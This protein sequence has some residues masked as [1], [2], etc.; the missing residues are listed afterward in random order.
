M[1]LNGHTYYS[2]KYGVLS[3]EA[4]AE[5]ASRRGITTLALTDINNTSCAVEWIS[6]CRKRDIKPV[7]GIEY[8]TTVETISIGRYLYTGIAKNAEGW[9]ELCELLTA[10]SLDGVPLPQRPPEMEHVYIIYRPDVFV[11]SDLRPNEF[12]GIKPAEA[13]GLYT[14]DWRNRLDRLVVWQPVTFDDDTG[15]KVHKLMRCVDL[16]IM[17]GQLEPD[18]CA[19]ADE[20]WV[21][22][23]Y[24]DNAFRGYPQI[25][26]NTESLLYQCEIEL[27]RTDKNNR[28]TFTGSERDDHQLLLKLAREGCRRRYGQTHPKAYARMESELKVI[29]QLGF[30]P[31]FLITWDIIRYAQTAGY[32]HVG[33][34]SGANSIVAYCLG[35]TDV[36]PLDLDL[37]FERFINPHRSS[38]PDF[39]I[40]FSWDERDDV[41]DYIFKRYGHRHTALLAT[42]N[43]FKGRSIIRELGKVVGL[44]KADID[45]IVEDPL[46]EGKHHP[47]ARHIFRYGEMIQKFPNYLSIHAGGVLVTERP[48]TYHTALQMMPKGFPVTHFD[49]YH[50]EDLGFHKYDVLS[51]RGLGHIKDAVKLIRLNQHKAVDIHD[52]PAIKADPKVRSQLRSGHCI[53]CFYIE[54]PAMR[55][56]L[57]KLRCDNYV[58]LVAASSIIRPGVAKS[59]MMREYI[60]RF[61]HPEKVEYLHPVFEQHLGETFGVMVYQEDVMKIVHHFAGLDLDESDVLRRI[62]TGKKKSSD[63]FRQLME[64]YW[65]NCRAR[66]YPEELIAEV[67]RQVESFSGY[68]FCKAHSASFAVESFQSLY[69]KTYYPLEFMVGVI[70]NFGGFYQT[71]Y[72]VHEARMCGADIQAPCVNHSL[73][74]THIYGQTIYLGLI[75]VQSLE[76]NTVHALVEERLRKG[77]YESL[78]DFV[79]RVEISREQ[80]DLLI[81]IGAFRFTGRSK[82]ELM[83]D[84]YGVHQPG[85]FDQLERQALFPREKTK[86]FELPLLEES[87]YDQS[88]DEMELLGFPLCNPF[89]LLA[90]RP[91]RETVLTRQLDDLVGKRVYML[92]YYVT[93]KPVTTVDGKHMSF[94]TWLDEEG[95]YFDTTHFPPVLA[96]YP[97]RGKGVYLIRGKVTEDFGFASVEAEGMERL[98]FRRD[99]R[100]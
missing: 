59:G 18:Q 35:I 54:S 69:L 94:G 76:A 82:C 63:T 44:P 50:A 90:E 39:D 14:S 21:D 29:R 89:S 40:D 23:Q 92:G 30:S 45:T 75:H 93:R 42:Y 79:R 55:G 2:F 10:C 49:M 96:R 25:L 6:E 3:P 36:D 71:E 88:F 95:K 11:P 9:R 33:R 65:R 85:R 1:Y 56:L 61:H 64:K 19:A 70:N 48:I 38:P 8:R 99:D 16:N 37:Y 73:N 74:L 13:N 62:M 57:N 22:R 46:A 12:I 15:F 41:T 7:L 51:Q 4:L 5:G 91:K 68:S 80:L 98:P 43:T 100:Y 84:K 86:T 97:F 81:R 24:I 77:P 83:W 66:G 78:D 52:V 60:K 67:W 47:Y 26:R 87:P 58:H 32:H 28:Q 53:G 17:L 31:Y 20:H 27:P 72:Y 34:G